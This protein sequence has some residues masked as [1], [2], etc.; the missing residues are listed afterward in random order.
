MTTP[1]LIIMGLACILLIVFILKPENDFKKLIRKNYVNACISG[2]VY[3]GLT[4][5]IFFGRIKNEVDE[6]EKA[7]WEFRP[8]AVRKQMA[9]V[10]REISEMAHY[11]EIDLIRN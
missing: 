6:L 9:R 5:K 3:K 4:K 11:Y 2:K 8:L 1:E 10:I 7:I